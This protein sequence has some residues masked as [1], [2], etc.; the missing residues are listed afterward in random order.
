MGH[1]PEIMRYDVLLEHG[2]S[3]GEHALRWAALARLRHGGA[4]AGR[5][6]AQRTGRDEVL[7][8]PSSASERVAS[9][10]RAL[11]ATRRGERGGRRGG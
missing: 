7:P 1:W 3:T 9:F 5:T 10:R 11:C 6:G 4:A 2:G 8:L